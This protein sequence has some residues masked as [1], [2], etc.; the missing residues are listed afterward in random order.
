MIAPS[1][2]TKNSLVGV[3][4]GLNAA[5]LAWAFASVLG[6]VALVSLGLCLRLILDQRRQGLALKTLAGEKAKLAERL[7]RIGRAQAEV[8]AASEA[9]SRFLATVSHEIRTP[10]NGVLGMADLMLDTRLDPEQANYARA[11][12][13][14]GEALLTLIEEILDFSRIEAGKLEIADED[15]ELAPLLEG[16]VELLAPRAQ[17]KGLEIAAHLAS[18]VPAVIRGDGNRLRQIV[19]NLAGNA[20][21][22]TEKGGVGLSVS[23]DGAQGLAIRIEDTGPGIPADRH[24][25]IFG[26]FEQADRETA[27]RHGGS[28]LGL[29][30][31]R[32]LARLMGGDITL[33]SEKD[34]GSVFTLFLPLGA[35]E[36]TAQ[37][38]PGIATCELA[39]RKVLVV[40]GG[41]FEGRFLARN[42]AEL[43]A[44]VRVAASKS[45]ALALLVG[46][47]PD[48]MMIDAA[49]GPEDARALVA[50]SHAAGCRRNLVLLSPFE[51]RAFG[52]P[53]AAGFD[54]YLVKPVRRRSL[55]AQITDWEPGQGGRN[56]APEAETMLAE[57]LAGQRVLIAEDNDIN[58]LLAGRLVERL[59]GKPMRA[60]TGREALDLLEASVAPGGV[61]FDCLLFDVRMPELDGLSAIAQWRAQEKRLKRAPIPALALTANAFRED[62]EACLAAGFDAFLP[63]PLDREPFLAALDRLLKNRLAV[64]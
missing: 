63:K 27:A 23:R 48:L 56:L 57:P 35:V 21:K 2:Q 15:V 42:L 17:G 44:E 62:R 11:I 41:A 22:F 28:G 13:T 53:Q 50:A 6:A 30:I 60:S 54:R 40:S 9:K 36:E 55:L 52:A 24:E 20:V 18:D 49:L 43:E 58:A 19:T 39:G 45:E 16:V 3:M 12:K 34:R 64:A 51:R 1:K 4:S 5:G 29:A 47:S 46:F 33:Q 32:R 37:S 59:G 26:E 25:A 61:P 10:L 38:R 14:S 31:S 7:E 8:E